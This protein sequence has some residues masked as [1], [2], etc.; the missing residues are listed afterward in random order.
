MKSSVISSSQT[1]LH[2]RYLTLKLGLFGLT[3]ATD[4][5]FMIT[6]CNFC[7]IC[8]NIN[9]TF[10]DSCITSRKQWDCHILC[11]ALSSQERQKLQRKASEVASSA[12]PCR[13][14]YLYVYGVFTVKV[15]PLSYLWKL[16]GF[17][18]P[19]TQ[20]SNRLLFIT[21]TLSFILVP[22]TS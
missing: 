3:L 13:I 21:T 5:P 22:Y 1:A 8:L 4:Y 2:T 16:Y 14:L 9:D 11:L 12:W 20:C 10:T 7:K 6:W 17:I 19:A 15:R 18:L